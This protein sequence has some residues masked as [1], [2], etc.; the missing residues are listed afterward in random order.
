MLQWVV[1]HLAAAGVPRFVVVVADL[2][3]DVA[4]WCRESWPLAQPP[5]LRVQAERLGMAHALGC[6]AAAL[7]GRFIM[8]ACDTIVEPAALARLMT[9]HVAAGAIVTLALETVPH[10]EAV[11][12]TAI[13]TRDGDRIVGIVEKPEPHEAPSNISSMPVY[14]CEPRILDYL[15]EVQPSPRGEYEIQDAIKLV[16]ARDR[17]CYGWMA[18]DRVQISDCDDLLALNRAWLAR[19]FTRATSDAECR[20]PVHVGPGVVCGPGCVLG[21]EAVIESGARLGAGVTVRRALVLGSAVVGDGEVVDG[22]V[23]V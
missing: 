8:H 12:K 11:R 14:L 13:V 9:N 10:P 1:E 2:D 23:R 20:G 18:E 21:P 17:G 15:P 3:D 6:A 22:E 16:I 5:R 7:D 19:G 4:R